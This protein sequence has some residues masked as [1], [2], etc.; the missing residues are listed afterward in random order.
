MYTVYSKPNCPQCVTLKTFL[1]QKQLD[2]QEIILDVGQ[3]RYSD[4]N[5]ISRDDLL[6]L[7][8]DAR[9]MPQVFKGDTLIGGY[10]DFL[11]FVGA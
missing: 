11:K 9:T 2:Y 6:K 10:S 1:K 5:Y 8:P 7:A 4:T 3:V